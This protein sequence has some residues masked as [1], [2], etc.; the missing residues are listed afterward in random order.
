MLFGQ[1]DD[2]PGEEEVV[3]RGEMTCSAVGE[4]TDDVSTSASLDRATASQPYH[5]GSCSVGCS[6]QFGTAINCP[7]FRLWMGWSSPSSTTCKPE[8]ISGHNDKPNV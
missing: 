8:F 2:G 5:F 3:R 7:W 4:W 1:A 6:N